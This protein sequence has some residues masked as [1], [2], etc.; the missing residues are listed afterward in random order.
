MLRPRALETGSNVLS[1]NDMQRIYPDSDT[2]HH[3]HKSFPD[4]GSK[5][6]VWF[7]LTTSNAIFSNCLPDTEDILTRFREHYKPINT[8]KESIS[9]FFQ[10]PELNYH[11]KEAEKNS[12]F[13][14]QLIDSQNCDNWI[15]FVQ[16]LTGKN[17]IGNYTNPRY[18]II[19]ETINDESSSRLWALPWSSTSL[20]E[21][22]STF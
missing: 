8:C 15:H 5:I 3:L 6:T 4:K 16:T 13:G 20:F 19:I 9:N 10:P 22:K 21:N 14:H 12:R 11:D 2:M 18:V 1:R 17:H 7:A